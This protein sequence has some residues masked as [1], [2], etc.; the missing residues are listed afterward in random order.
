M[1]S[2]TV[3]SDLNAVIQLPL[4][5]PLGQRQEVEAV[6]DTGFNG[7]VTLPPSLISQLGLKRRGRGRAL[8]ADGSIAL[9]DIYAVT[10]IW[11]GVSRT[12]E[13]DA[14]DVG[15]LAG[16]SLLR[17]YRLHIQVTDGGHTQIEP[18]G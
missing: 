10:V 18:L 4:V 13:V 11:D 16:M 9:F 3:N 6:I 15:V 14:V 1:I 5:G 12:V 17:G 8:L 2:G 7:Y